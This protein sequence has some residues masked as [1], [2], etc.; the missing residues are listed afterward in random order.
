M[1]DRCLHRDCS[2]PTRQEAE[3]DAQY[4]RNEDREPDTSEWVQPEWMRAL[5]EA[6]DQ[7]QREV[8]DADDARADQDWGWEG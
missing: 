5:T 4:D 6:E 1:P 3:R 8:D 7:H 2:C